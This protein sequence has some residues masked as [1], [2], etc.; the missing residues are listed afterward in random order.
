MKVTDYLGAMTGNEKEAKK[1]FSLSFST[2]STSARLVFHI[3]RF[4]NVLLIALFQE[5]SILLDLCFLL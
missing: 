5:A 3:I 1:V 2:R 4:K